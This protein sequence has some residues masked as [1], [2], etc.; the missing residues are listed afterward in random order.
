MLVH[1]ENL[2]DIA[3]C[4]SRGDPLDPQLACWLSSCLNVFLSERT[5]HMDEAFGIR[6]PRGGV[7]WRTEYAMRI[8]DAALRQLSQNLDRSR[9]PRARAIEIH[10]LTMSYATTS[11]RWDKTKSEMPPQYSGTSKEQLW[12]A[13]HSGAPMPIGERRLRQVLA[14]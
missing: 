13:F 9:S 14:E 4:C 5:N 7:P 2:R 8:R 12:I 3:E 10:R 1:I 11:W 6:S